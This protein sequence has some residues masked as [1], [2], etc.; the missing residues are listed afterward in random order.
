MCRGFVI[1]GVI[2]LLRRRGSRFLAANQM[3]VWGIDRLICSIERK[4]WLINRR[5]SQLFLGKGWNPSASDSAESLQT[6]RLQLPMPHELVGRVL[7]SF[8]KCGG[9]QNYEQAHSEQVLSRCSK[10]LLPRPSSSIFLITGWDAR[11]VR[12][13]AWFLSEIVPDK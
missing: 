8:L 3:G 12:L 2:L 5:R 6:D 10:S 7:R 4:P 13:P 11:P 9:P 1:L